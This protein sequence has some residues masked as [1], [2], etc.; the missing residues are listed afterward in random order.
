[1]SAWRIC[2]CELFYRMR[3]IDAVRGT[4][5]HLPLTQIALADTLGLSSVHVNRTLQDL[6]RDGL[7][8]FR[9][10]EMTINNLPALEKAGSFTPD[11]LHLQR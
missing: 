10:G 11:Y 2:F 4:S 7:V 6:R 1:M 9:G 3:S 5:Y 8:S